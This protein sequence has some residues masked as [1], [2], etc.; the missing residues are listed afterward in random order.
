MEK[1]TRL[2]CT[3]IPNDKASSFTH[4]IAL[5]TNWFFEL[6]MRPTRLTSTTQSYLSSSECQGMKSTE[7]GN[8]RQE[9]G[10]PIWTRPNANKSIAI[11]FGDWW[12]A[13]TALEEAWPRITNSVPNL[14]RALVVFQTRQ[15]SSRELSAPHAEGNA[16]PWHKFVA[17]VENLRRC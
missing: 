14:G 1:R 7:A 17:A 10:F 6:V 5:E 3:N 13:T 2:Q 8:R 9:H 15:L 16:G 4:R 11:I 12:T